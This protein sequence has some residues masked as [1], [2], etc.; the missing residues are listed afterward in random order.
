MNKNVCFQGR[1]RINPEVRVCRGP[2]NSQPRSD[3]SDHQKF[4]KYS[5]LLN[6]P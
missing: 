5:G 6:H 1:K 3:I 4:I 2:E